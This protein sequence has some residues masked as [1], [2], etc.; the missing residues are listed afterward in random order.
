[1]L[2]TSKST[3]TCNNTN[4]MYEIPSF[5]A[6]LLTPELEVLRKKDNKIMPVYEDSAGNKFLKLK[7]DTGSFVKR[8]KAAIVALAIPVIAPEGFTEVPSYKGLFVSKE[9]GVWSAPSHKF[10]LGS[11]LK[12][13]DNPNGYSSIN[14]TRHGCVDVHKL[15]ALT[16]LDKE[17]IQKGLCV[18][19]LDDNKHNFSLKNLKVGTYSENNKAAYANGLNSGNGLKK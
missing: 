11:Y 2:V 8:A 18:M 13:Y 19:H 10:P 1:M 12:A 6:Y 4:Y 5:S 9:G 14:T 15:L 16:Y 3:E 17:Y 7:T